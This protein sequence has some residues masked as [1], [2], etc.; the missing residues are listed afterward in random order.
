[1]E[2]RTIWVCVSCFIPAFRMIIPIPK[3]RDSVEYIDEFLD[4]ILNEDL[5]YNAEWDFVDGIS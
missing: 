4:C 3:D 1:M 5:R 2:I